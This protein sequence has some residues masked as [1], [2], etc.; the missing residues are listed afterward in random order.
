MIASCIDHTLLAPD[1]SARAV[2]ILC[3][4]AKAYH[5]ATVCVAPYRVQQAAQ[6]LAGSGVG[7]T[8]V[9]GFPHGA[10][11]GPAKAAEASWA[12]AQGATEIDMVQNIGA[13]KDGAWDMVAKEIRQVRAAIGDVTLKVILET[14]LLTPTEIVNACK[15]AQEV[16]ADFVKT[17]TGFAG[18]GATVANVKLMRDTVGPHFGVKASGGIRDLATARAM[19]AA[20]ANRLGVSAGV[21]IARAEQDEIK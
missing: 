12:L 1:A 7:V 6:A 13:V 11:G 16:G 18:A 2:E 21:A 19:L 9:V 17:S 14:A 8:T 4:D 15:L 20:G 5:F 10:N 3:E